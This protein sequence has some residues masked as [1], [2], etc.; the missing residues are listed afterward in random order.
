MNSPSLERLAFRE[1]FSS[2]AAVAISRGVDANGFD[3]DMQL[4]FA[5]GGLGSITVAHQR[6]AG[7]LYG[8]SAIRDGDGNA[9]YD[10]FSFSLS[11]YDC[12]RNGAEVATRTNVEKRSD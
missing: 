2:K 1:T 12:L 3:P 6:L 4:A 9:D 10:A 11:V 5:A 7:Q 8:G